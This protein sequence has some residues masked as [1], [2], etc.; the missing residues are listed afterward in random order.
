MFV[1]LLLKI[2]K[3]PNAKQDGA[4]EENQMSCR[5]FLLI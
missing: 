2:L 4:T 1:T 3:H 5:Y